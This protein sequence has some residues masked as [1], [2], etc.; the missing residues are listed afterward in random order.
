M[1]AIV[2]PALREKLRASTD[3]LIQR[4]G[5]GT[6]TMFLGDEMY[7]GND[8]LCMVDHVLSRLAAR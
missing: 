7:F 3:E 1:S 2:S 4:G 8:R 6:P 5:F